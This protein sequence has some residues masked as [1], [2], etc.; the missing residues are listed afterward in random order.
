MN[1][2]SGT[3]VNCTPEQ[4]QAVGQLREYVSEQLN[5]QG[6]EISTWFLLRIGRARNFNV[7]L[8]KKMMSE[9]KDFRMSEF[10][11]QAI[12]MNVES[13][14]KPLQEL[15][16]SGFFNTDLEGRPVYV[17]SV[18]TSAW[19]KMMAN[20]TIDEIVQ[21]HLKKLE[22]FLLIM[23]PMASKAFGK[24]VD[25]VTAIVDFKDVNPLMFTK[26]KL[27][28]FV[29]KLSY[30]TQNF[31]PEILGKLYIINVPKLFYV[32][33]MIV[34]LWLDDQT[35]RKIEIDSGKATEK[36]LKDIHPNNLHIKFGG[37]CE[38]YFK[39]DI[40]PWSYELD[41]AKRQ[42]V[43]ST[44]SARRM[45]DKYFLTEIEQV[46]KK[47][48]ESQIENQRSL[49]LMEIE[50]Q[51]EVRKIPHIKLTVSMKHF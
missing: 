1:T 43:H 40:G 49:S 12:D 35:K 36:L 16:D 6:P 47:V 33:W 44:P 7:E 5:Y 39:E 23:N 19:E 45:F 2:Q 11:G 9:Y 51:V 50:E 26:G 32:L 25:C 37:K 20:Y 46:K 18:G 14:W 29:Q 8:M 30:Y 13:K 42:N 48:T 21:W 3:L 38:G 17:L 4:L 34:K 28:E 22:W 15:M 41:E 31:Y 10:F 27:K 24:R